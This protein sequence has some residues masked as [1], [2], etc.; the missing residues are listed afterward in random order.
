MGLNQ[1][2][3][4]KGHQHSK[5]TLKKLEKTWFKKGDMI[6]NQFAKGN[7][8]NRTSFKKGETAWN[9]GLKGYGEGKVHPYWK[10]ENAS[11][12]SKHSWLKRKYGNPKRC[13]DCEEM[14][15][16][17]LLKNGIKRWTIEWSNIDGKYR[18]KKQGYQGRCRKCHKKYDTQLKN[19][20]L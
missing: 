18:R 13:I 9:K 2:S 16:Y 3:F 20:T 8:P 10:G 15:K 19:K 6:G 7:S 11:Y 17:T 4:K 12:T 5:K 14:G 1:T